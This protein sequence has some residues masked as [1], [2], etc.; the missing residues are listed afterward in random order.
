MRTISAAA[1]WNG[2]EFRCAG[3]TLVELSCGDAQ[4]TDPANLQTMVVP[5]DVTGPER[6]FVAT[7]TKVRFAS[8]FPKFLG[9]AKA[10]FE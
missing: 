5:Q 4:E 6:T 10:C 1:A 7:A 3:A 9:S 8:T 2:E